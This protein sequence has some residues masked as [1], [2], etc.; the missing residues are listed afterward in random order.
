MQDRQKA[1][2]LLG[3]AQRAGRLTTGTETV[4]DKLNKGKIKVVIMASDIQKNTAEKVDRAARK[5][6]VPIINL[7]SADEI[8]QA[9]SKNRK[10]LGLTDAG[11]AKA[12]VKKINEGV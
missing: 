4:I 7:F 1:I 2:N 3:L 12:L 8:A 10:V 11:F 9:I 6:N 5:A